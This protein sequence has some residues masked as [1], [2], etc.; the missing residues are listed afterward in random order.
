MHYVIDPGGPFCEFP[1][2]MTQLTVE[3]AMMRVINGDHREAREHGQRRNLDEK[4]L[5]LL[6]CGD[7]VCALGP[8][9]GMYLM[10]TRQA[11]ARVLS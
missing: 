5:Q 10:P 4:L 9:D 3:D 8:D 7:I 2:H 1:P 11:A 6:H